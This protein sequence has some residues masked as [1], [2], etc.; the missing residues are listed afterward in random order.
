MSDYQ[1]TATEE[2]CAVIRYS[3]KACIPP[4]M[5]NRDYNGDQFSPGYIQ[6]LE[7]GGV[8]DPYVPPE[9]V[10]PTA[11]S[12][13]QL[14]YDHE[15]LAASDGRPAAAR[16]RRLPAE[17][18]RRL[19]HAQ[20]SAAASIAR[21]AQVDTTPPNTLR[22]LPGS[23][24]FTG[25]DMTPIAG[26]AM[27]AGAGAFALTDPGTTQLGNRRWLRMP[28]GRTLLRLDQQFRH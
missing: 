16:A 1:L 14:L 15:N 11:T 27:A 4:D 19:D 28:H 25:E 23:F 17:S 18:E 6:W 12:E 9:P 10:P 21:S 7:A 13:Q 8:P 20:V 24:V 26:Y 22:A 3:D 2:P 5:A